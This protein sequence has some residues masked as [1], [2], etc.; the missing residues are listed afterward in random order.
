VWQQA[1]DAMVAVLRTSTV[2]EL[3]GKAATGAVEK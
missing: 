2:T 1:Q 3:A